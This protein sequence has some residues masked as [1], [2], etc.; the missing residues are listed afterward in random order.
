LSAGVQSVG[1]EMM[2]KGGLRLERV[3]MFPDL[4]ALAWSD[5]IL[6]AA[7]G[8]SLLS[9][10]VTKFPLEWKF[11]ARHLPPWWR[12]LTATFSLT[13]RLVRDGFHALCVL[14]S[15]DLIAAVP[16]AI[17]TLSSGETEFRVTHKI[18]RGTRPL[19]ICTVP[20]GDVYWGEYF[21]NPEREEVHIYKSS[22]RGQSWRVAYT[23]PAG[24][25]RHVHNIIYDR[26]KKCLWI[27]TGDNGNECRILRA[28]CNL[29]NV[30]IVMSGNQQARSV[31]LVPTENGLYFSSDTPLEKNHIYCL[32]R[33]DKLTALAD[34]PS[35]SI[36]G[37]RANGAMF[38][39]TMVEPSEINREQ[40]VRLFGSNDGERWTRQAS[41]KKD[42][43]QM[44]LFQYGNAALPD[45]ENDTDLLAVSTIA[46]EKEDLATSLWRVIC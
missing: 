14:P 22:D 30:E 10:D 42:R 38:F 46:V 41:W 9:A 20:N 3:A 13:F 37:C 34:L 33:N 8:Y 24:T 6:Y 35:S 39:S 43:W 2:R 26:W 4:R 21:D 23:F 7:R 12:N 16:G 27:L 28:S 36:Y 32:D 18:K 29:E 19:H 25:I 1:L 5:K 11:V 44:G 17:V 15:G 45:G 31:A 40:S